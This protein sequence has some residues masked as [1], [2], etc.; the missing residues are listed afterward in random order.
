[1]RNCDLLPTMQ[2]GGT[3]LSLEPDVGEPMPVT[4]DHIAL[5]APTLEAGRGYIRDVLDVVPSPGGQHPQMGTHNELVRLGD[6]MFLEIIARDPSAAPP[7]THAAWFDLG[8]DA[9]TKANWDAGIRLRGMVG[10]TSDLPHAV[11]RAPD[12]LGTP[13]RLTRGTREWMFATRRDG[14][15]PQGGALPHI[16]DWG[17]QGA[18]GPKL[19]DLGC[20]LLR[21]VLETPEDH[22]VIGWI[23][24]GLGF[25]RAPEIR[26]GPRTRLI[27]A[28]ETPSGVRI[29]T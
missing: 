17:A 1:M 29:L 28:I 20:R 25:E 18:A 24:G 13:M 26:P 27:A 23:Y 9:R 14:T 11:S 6:D 16:M 19:P 7:T 5:F 3:T 4:L 22:A 2:T 21:L 12:E 10:R 15:L 8:N